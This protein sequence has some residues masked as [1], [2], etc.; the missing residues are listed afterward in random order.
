MSTSSHST[1]VVSG[2]TWVS[3]SPAAGPLCWYAV[4]TRAR[5]EKKV[6]QELYGRGVDAFLPLTT[7]IHFWSD[8]RQRVELPLFAGYVFVHTPVFSHPLQVLTAPGVLR[9][10]GAGGK[11]EP[12][13][14][15]EMEQIKRILDC[16]AG[17]FPHPYVKVGQRVRIR[18]GCL[19]GLEGVIAGQGRQNVLVVSVG[20]IQKSVAVSLDSY[21]VEPA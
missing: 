13:P 1:G 2:C 3:S 15:S 8:R 17:L 20:A 18:G 21:E 6:A 5:H 12:I 10:V 16:R 14:D 7:E 9:F 19:D 4:Q 11:R